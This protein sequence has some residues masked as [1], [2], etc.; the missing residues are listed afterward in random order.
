LKMPDVLKKTIVTQVDDIQNE[1]TFSNDGAI[2][3]NGKALP[4]EINKISDAEL[5]LSLYGKLYHVILTEG[6][7]GYLVLVNGEAF[8]VKIGNPALEKLQ[9]IVGKASAFRHP[10]EIRAPMPGLVVKREVTEGENVK[11]GQGIVI[12]EAMKMENEV[13]SPKTGV[14]Q[15]LFVEDR[16]VVE[17]GEVLALIL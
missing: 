2:F 13:K 12:L 6:N 10:D 16:Q 11:I 1:W 14:V 4:A 15:K 17:K 3:V 9:N 5:S 8:Q 7:G